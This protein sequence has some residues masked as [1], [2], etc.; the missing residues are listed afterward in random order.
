[1]LSHFF[2]LVVYQPLYNGLI[3]LMSIM[4]WADAGI[5]VVVFTF[6]VKLILFPLSQ[7]ATRTQLKMKALESDLALLKEKHK[8]DRE[9][10]AKATMA[11]YKEKKV[12]PFSTFFLVLIQIPII[13]ALYYI[14]YSGG[15]PEIKTDLLYPLVSAP[16]VTMYFLGFVD[17]TKGSLLLAILVS[18]SQYFQVRFSMP[19]IKPKA[20]GVS[21]K[22]DFARNLNFQMRYFLP[23]L[24]G[25]FAFNLPGAVSLYWITSNLFAIGQELYVRRSFFGSRHTNIPMDTNML[26]AT[27]KKEQN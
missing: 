16:K 14:F 26:I 10:H 25:V 24:V 17:I 3:F 6:L 11:F 18:V 27:N 23:A 4:P 13:F 1:M 12:N 22:D 2:N 21:M 8:G 19:A 7:K 20:P 15:L 9:A 5:S